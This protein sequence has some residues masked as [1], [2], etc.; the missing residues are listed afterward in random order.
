MKVIRGMSLCEWAHLEIHGKLT[1][2]VTP[3]AFVIP[4]EELRDTLPPLPPGTIL[5]FSTGRVLAE[6]LAGRFGIVVV[7][8]QIPARE[9]VWKGIGRYQFHDPWEEDRWMVT[10]EEVATRRILREWVEEVEFLVPPPLKGVQRE[11]IKAAPE[12]WVPWC[13]ENGNPGPHEAC[14][15][16]ALRRAECKR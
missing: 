6:N 13:E 4:G 8:L 12:V 9:I 2:E 3:W 14:I 15:K 11:W 1:P 16:W 5:F 7:R 10:M